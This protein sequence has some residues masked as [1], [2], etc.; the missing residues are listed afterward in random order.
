MDRALNMNEAS[1]WHTTVLLL[2]KP[3]RNTDSIV[4]HSNLTYSETVFK[5]LKDFIASIPDEYMENFPQ[6]KSF[7]KEASEIEK[8]RTTFNLYPRA[9]TE[10]H[11]R[12]L[13]S[14]QYKFFNKIVNTEKKLFNLKGGPGYG[15]TFLV[16]ALLAHYE[17]KQKKAVPAGSTGVSSVQIGGCTIHSLLI[18]RKNFNDEWI[19][20]LSTSGH[21]ERRKAIGEIDLLII[22]EISMIGKYLFEFIM[23]LFLK[24]GKT[25]LKILLVGDPLI[26]WKLLVNHLWYYQTYLNHSNLS[27]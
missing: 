20:L 9:F 19:S 24:Y 27:R 26:N 4:Q 13:N 14:E 22:D 2:H 16:N 6:D 23:K 5:K 18:L 15:K 7:E 12:K 3:Y 17:L 21:V 11:V 10:N 25:S 1:I 8:M